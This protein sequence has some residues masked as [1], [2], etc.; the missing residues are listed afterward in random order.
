MKAEQCICYD[1]TS[2]WEEGVCPAG[3]DTSPF[4]DKEAC[5]V[6]KHKERCDV[7]KHPDIYE[8]KH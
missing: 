4:Y 7:P 2:V 1:C 6:C 3:C 8:D 5:S